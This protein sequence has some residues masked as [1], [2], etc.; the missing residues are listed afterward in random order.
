[1]SELASH[2]PI[3]LDAMG[4]DNAP[5]EILLGAADAVSAYDCGISLVGDRTVLER[6]LNRLGITDDARL[7][8]LC[9][10]DAS[11]VIEMD[12]HP[13]QAV[14]QKKDSS[15]VRACQLVAAGE[16]A[17]AVSA[18]NSGAMLAA[19]LMALR[20][21]EG[22][23]RPAIGTAFPTSTGY[24]FV[25][26]AGANTDCRPEW[27]LQFA[28]MGNVYAKTMMNVEHPRVALLS[29]GEEPTKGSQTVIEAH[30]LIGRAPLRFVGN[31][32]G[33]DLF[34][35]SCDV[36]VTDGFVG[37]VALKTAEGVG[38]F[39]FAAMREAAM[40]SVSGKVGG[41]LLKPKL[42]AIR[43]RVDPSNTGGALLLGVRGEAVIAHGRSN[44]L[45]IKNAIRVAI[46]AVAANVS[47][48]IA[49]EM[50]TLN[51]SHATAEASA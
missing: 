15:M 27:L 24:T 31:V 48:V 23:S 18:G 32:E 28:V 6:E 1:M 39:L 13:A 34:N 41:A 50:A 46:E 25:I 51:A 36:A 30:Q 49:S 20:R 45:A 33:R 35:G 10:V 47:G 8:R 26:D 5:G 43:D 12:E 44:A 2:L 11:E 3:A 7:A 19:S 42:R 29:N 9:I 17:A 21:I 40:S 38:E 14:K 22:V 4:G 37:N 16:A